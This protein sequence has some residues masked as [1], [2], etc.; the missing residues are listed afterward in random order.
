[1][2]PRN[3]KKGQKNILIITS[4]L[5]ENKGDQAILGSNIYFMKKYL[6]N[7]NIIIED[8]FLDLFKSFQTIRHVYSADAVVLSVGHPVQDTTSKLFIPYVFSKIVLAILLNKKLFIFSAGIS[9]LKS[10]FLKKLVVIIMN[11]CSFIS[12][13]DEES[14]QLLE[15]FGVKKDIH[16]SCDPALFYPNELFSTQDISIQFGNYKPYICISP[17]RWFHYTGSFFP[18]KKVDAKYLSRIE[19]YRNQLTNLADG[20]VSK[21]NCNVILVPMRPGKIDHPGQDDDI[22]CN[23]IL[24]NAKNK[25]N[26]IAIDSPIN[27]SEMITLFRGA[28]AV[29]GVRMHSSI[30]A[31]NTNT[32]FINI[33]YNEKGLSFMTAMDM[34]N[35]TISIEDFSH[36]KV[37]DLLTDIFKN[38]KKIKSQMIRRKNLLYGELLINYAKMREIMGR[39]PDFPSSS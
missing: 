31:A 12:V 1:M 36:E 14:K 19:L 13:R 3:R 38:K 8:V 4:G 16:I 37:L 6:S 33:Y 26:I 7:I 23:E 27:L 10:K 34:K 29:V 21:F 24:N 28:E 18:Y 5:T 25:N 17:R 9:D 30:L 32:P 35:Y 11:K 20:V 2:T 39:D 15:K 22:F